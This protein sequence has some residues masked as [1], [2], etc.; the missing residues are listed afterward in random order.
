M[1][2]RNTAK[3]RMI[4][5]ELKSMHTHPTATELVDR[6]AKKNCPVSRATVFRVLSDLVDDGVIM[7]VEV[8]NSDT[9]YDGNTHPHYHF[10]CRVCG[11]VEDLDLPY[12]KEMDRAIEK[13]GYQVEGHSAEFYGVCPE[14]A[15]KL[16]EKSDREQSEE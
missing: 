9:R 7:R 1:E 8:E 12:Q 3:K 16:A 5:E 4:V 10:K 14:C 6:L 15:R 2:R 11:K 13:E